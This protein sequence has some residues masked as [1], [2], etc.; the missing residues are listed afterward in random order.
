MKPT[1]MPEHVAEHDVGQLGDADVPD[2][3]G[4]RDR[5]ADEVADR[6]DGAA[7]SIEATPTARVTASLAVITRPRCGT[8]VNDVSPVR[9]LHSLVTESTATIGRTT[10]IGKPIAAANAS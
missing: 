4:A 10:A 7:S 6:A 9:W 3:V 8:R 2:R 5:G 1:S